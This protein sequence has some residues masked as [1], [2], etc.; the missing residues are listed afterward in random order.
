MAERPYVS[1]LLNPKL[2]A[3]GRIPQHDIELLF[4]HAPGYLDEYVR[5]LEHRDEVD[6]VL[7]VHRRH[8]LR[9]CSTDSSRPPPSTFFRDEVQKEPSSTENSP[10]LPLTKSENHWDELQS[11]RN[12]T[13]TLNIYLRSNTTPLQ[14]AEFV[15][16]LR[17]RQDTL[18]LE[19]EALLAWMRRGE[20]HKDLVRTGNS[21][22]TSQRY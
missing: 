20:E 10:S 21:F 1:A 13:F 17:D 18:Y 11:L 15:K 8:G 6:L 7:R 4:V 9:L 12:Q 16:F 5:A 2:F 3:D 19:R 14:C 22:F